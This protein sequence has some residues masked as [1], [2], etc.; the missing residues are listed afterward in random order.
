MFLSLTI[1]AEEFVIQRV[2]GIEVLGLFED[3]A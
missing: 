2:Q 1:F 3:K